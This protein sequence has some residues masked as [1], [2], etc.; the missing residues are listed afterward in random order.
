M[1]K[2][3]YVKMPITIDEKHEYHRKGFRVIDARF[4]PTDAEDEPQVGEE[5]KPRQRRRRN[6]AEDEE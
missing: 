5:E 1:L 4:K 2:P 6:V 3:I